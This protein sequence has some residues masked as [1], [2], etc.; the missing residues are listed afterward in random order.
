MQR[1]DASRQNRKSEARSKIIDCA[2]RSIRLHGASKVSVSDVMKEAGLT[3]GTFY[4]HFDSKDDLV[5]EAVKRA[6]S[7]TLADFSD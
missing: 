4:A 2:S 1:V 6:A 3:H 5:A 7:T